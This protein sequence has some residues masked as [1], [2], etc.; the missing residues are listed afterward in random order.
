MP[1]HDRSPGAQ[2]GHADDAAPR[3]TQAGGRDST[4]GGAN[5][6]CRSADI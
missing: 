2:V 4:V 5:L 1:A 6:A 3:P